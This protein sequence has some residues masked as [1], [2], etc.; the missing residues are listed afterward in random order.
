MILTCNDVTSGLFSASNHLPQQQ[1]A[2]KTSRSPHG[3]SSKASRLHLPD[4]PSRRSIKHLSVSV[5]RDPTSGRGGGTGRRDVK[6]SG[7]TANAHITLQ[8]SSS[9]TRTSVAVSRE[10]VSK[11]S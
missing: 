9:D 4:L 1:V 5:N 7:V 3:S 6:P 2:A 10:F 8:T 11:V